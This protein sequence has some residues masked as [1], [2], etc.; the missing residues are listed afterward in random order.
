MARIGVKE[1]DETVCLFDG[2]LRKLSMTVKSV[3]YVTF[4]DFLGR[5]ITY[6]KS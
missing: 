3:E 4:S 1:L 2:Y 6:K 5:K